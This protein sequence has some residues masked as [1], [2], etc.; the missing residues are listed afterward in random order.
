M[1]F[2]LRRPLL[3]PA[4]RQ[5]QLLSPQLC[6][7]PPA[8]RAQLL[9]ARLCPA[10]TSRPQLR[11]VVATSRPPVER[12][13]APQSTSSAQISC[14]PCSMVLL[15]VLAGRLRFRLRRARVI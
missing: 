12:R 9:V 4:S 5:A 6:P 1:I 8:R 14:F 11:L 13:P 2:L 15:P 7:P 10:P 3:R